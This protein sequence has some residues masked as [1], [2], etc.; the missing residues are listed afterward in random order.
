MGR[1]DRCIAVQRAVPELPRLVEIRG[2]ASADFELAAAAMGDGEPSPRQF[3]ARIDARCFGGGAEAPHRFA[4]FTGV[5][6]R[7]AFA[8]QQRVAVEPLR[9]GGA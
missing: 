7:L 1:P 5:Q 8:Q 9:R 3:V 4:E 2:P 6:R